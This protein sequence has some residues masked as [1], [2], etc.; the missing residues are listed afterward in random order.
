M[1]T[2]KEKTSEGAEASVL[3]A[4][5][6]LGVEEMNGFPALEQA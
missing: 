6:L 4:T 3:R 2:V 5:M 1:W